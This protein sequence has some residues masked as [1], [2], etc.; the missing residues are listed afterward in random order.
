[1]SKK[2]QFKYKSDF[3]L[4]ERKQESARILRDHPNRMPVICEKAP[5]STL[6]DI[7]KTK[8]LVPGDMSVNQFHFL[9]RRN[10]DL[11]EASALYLITP[12]GVTLTGDKTIMEVYNN[13]KDK[14][15]NFLYLYY[16][17]ELTWGQRQFRDIKDVI[18]YSILLKGKK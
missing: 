9:I 4:E 10:L 13:N 18:N 5:N 12:K 6:P 14:N 15:D 2:D 11:N 17:S 7:K 3:S 8:Y 16:A 1:M